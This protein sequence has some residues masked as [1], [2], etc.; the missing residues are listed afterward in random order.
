MPWSDGTFIHND[1]LHLAE[2]QGYQLTNA[3][4]MYGL[5]NPEFLSIWQ[6]IGMVGLKKCHN[7]WR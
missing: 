3:Q 4:A 2:A 5:G 7:L 6:D 1:W